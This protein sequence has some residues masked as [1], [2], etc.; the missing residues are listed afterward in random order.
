MKTGFAIAAFVFLKYNSNAGMD[1]AENIQ[2]LYK[3]FL[4]IYV[5]SVRG[6]ISQIDFGHVGE[7]RIIDLMGLVPIIQSGQ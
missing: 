7:S 2:K 1:E 6:S 5:T 4:Y 3:I